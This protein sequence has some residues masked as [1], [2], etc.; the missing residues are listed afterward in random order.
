MGDIGMMHDVSYSKPQKLLEEEPLFC[1]EDDPSQP[2][3]KKLSSE[4]DH[5]EWLLLVAYM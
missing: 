4:D 3:R 5:Y 2:I 1:L